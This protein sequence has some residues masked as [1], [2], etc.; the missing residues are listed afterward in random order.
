MMYTDTKT[1]MLTAALGNLLE[2]GSEVEKT[3]PFRGFGDPLDIARA[4][5]FFGSEDAS[6]VT[7]ALLPV[8]GGISA[9]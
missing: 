7:G 4:A 2:A 1:P 3:I 8:D 5:V 9:Q 6:W